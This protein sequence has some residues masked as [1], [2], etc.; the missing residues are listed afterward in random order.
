MPIADHS[1]I[2]LIFDM[3]DYTI[4]Y[5]II[6]T[7]NLKCREQFSGTLCFIKNCSDG[8]KVRNQKCP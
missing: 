2:S 1:M 3:R 7:G 5:K 6:H 4:I 8:I